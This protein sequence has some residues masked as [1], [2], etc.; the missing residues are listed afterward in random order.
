MAQAWPAED[1]TGGGP[2]KSCCKEP[3]PVPLHDP[4]LDSARFGITAY[5]L[6]NHGA[7]GRGLVLPVGGEDTDGLV[8][9][10]QTVDT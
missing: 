3:E 2:N 1:H 10:G 4:L 6:G 8:V 5:R 7:G 9:A